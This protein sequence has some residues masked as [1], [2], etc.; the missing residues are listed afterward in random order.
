MDGD[1]DIAI[2]YTEPRVTD[3]I[4]DLLWMVR[5]TILCSP[6]AA[7]DGRRSDP[8]KFIA[9]CD[10]LHVKLENRPRHLFW[11][12]LVRSI[13]R[14]DLAVDR[15]LVFDT[16]QLAAQYAMLGD[17]L[18]LADPLLFAEEIKAGRLV[19]PFD[20]WLDEGF[21]YYLTTHPEDLSNEAVA[22]F[23]SWLIARFSA[24][25]ARESENAAAEAPRLRPTK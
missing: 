18:V 10:L 13:G 5:S 23:R 9:A 11:E 20:I 4:H 6:Q 19:Q 14:P 1:I 24:D 7:A 16:P 15:G 17:G 22:L 12:M 8:A 25:K 3:A 2:V 21:G